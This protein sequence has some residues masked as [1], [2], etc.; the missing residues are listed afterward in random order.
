MKRLSAALCLLVTVP[1]SQL[2]A[3][4]DQY[5]DPDERALSAPLSVTESPAALADWLTGTSHSERDKARA[6]FRWITANISYDADAFFSGQIAPASAEDALRSRRGVCE[7]Y[8]GLFSELC[9]KAGLEVAGIPG[10]AKGYGYAAGRS[11]GRKP[12]HSWNAIRLDGRW[13]LIDCTWGAGYIGD[14]RRFHRQFNPHY[15]LTSPGEFIYDHFPEKDSWQL[16][17]PP[18]SREEFENTV[19]LKPAFFVLG[20]SVG[21]NGAGTLRTDGEL[22]LRLG[23]TGSVAGAATLTSENS[24]LDERTTFVQQEG[25]AL[26]VRASIPAGDRTLRLFAR[27]A[28]TPGEYAWILDYRVVSTG[29]RESQ[30]LYPKKYGA[31]DDRRVVLVEPVRGVLPR[32]TTRFHIHA[33]GAE[34]AAV[35]VGKAWSVLDGT[36]G[37][38]S[39]VAHVMPG[40]V[41]LCARYPGHEE[42]ESLLEYRGK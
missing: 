1:A 4:E 10:Y 6:I 22:T 14:D 35:V 32:G 18:R 37:E 13:Q 7:G 27:S 12:N 28:G 31:F 19:Y 20:F 41:T 39:G 8:A 36:A 30:S 26:V 21:S 9:R 11:S 3:Q 29:R 24:T 2:I 33:P 38:F 17:D 25:Q 23:V 15:F 34:Q 16:L 40:A 42:W 5:R